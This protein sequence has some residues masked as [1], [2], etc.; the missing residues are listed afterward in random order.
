MRRFVFGWMNVSLALAGVAL[1]GLSQSAAAQHMHAESGGGSAV[2]DSSGAAFARQVR[3]ATERFARLDEAIAAGYRL[4]GPDFPGMGEHWVNIRAIMMKRVDPAHPAVLSYLRVA[5]EAVLTGAAFAVPLRPGEAPPHL[6]FPVSWHRHSGS[7]AEETLHLNPHAMESAPDGP[8][9]A[10]IH[11]WVW[12]TNPAGTFAQQNWTL[13]FHRLGLGA[14]EGV[15]PP[16]GKAAHLAS[17]GV[18][19][20]AGVIEQAG[21][22]AAPE[23]ESVREALQEAERD[24]H[25]I[26]GR[27]SSGRLTGSECIGRLE[28]RWE[29]M[30]DD[31]HVRVSPDVANRL[32]PLSR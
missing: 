23:V 30:W 21:R 7:I 5:G 22:P 16:A 20:Y 28:A 14:P 25:E 24:V 11:A 4:V 13:P 10:M 29:R 18:D 19:Y 15:T 31:I 2:T 26:I 12:T 9:L 27:W 8:E 3:A 32:A 1:A 17:G 6:P